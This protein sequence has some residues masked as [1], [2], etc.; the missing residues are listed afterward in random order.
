MYIKSNAIANDRLLLRED[1]EFFGDVMLSHRTTLWLFDT[2]FGWLG[3]KAR[4][5]RAIQRMG[6]HIDCGAGNLT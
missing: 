1:E 2:W 3:C 4:L 5:D 6:K